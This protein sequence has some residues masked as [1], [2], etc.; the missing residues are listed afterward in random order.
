MSEP[1]VRWTSE[2]EARLQRAPAFLRGMVRRLAEYFVEMGQLNYATAVGQSLRRFPADLGAW[3]GRTQIE[4]ATGNQP[5]Q[6]ASLQ[7]RR[8]SFQLIELSRLA[9]STPCT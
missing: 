2:A 8:N 3:I 1:E 4:M 7:P 5:T 9:I 6:A